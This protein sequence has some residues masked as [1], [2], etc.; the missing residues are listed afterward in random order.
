MIQ[1][2][3]LSLILII[4]AVVWGGLLLL[5]GVAVSPSW[6]RPLSGVTAVL[7]GLIGCFDLFLWR[8][9]ILQ[10]W[11]VKRPIL[12]G[13]W[14][15]KLVSNWVNPE[16]GEKVPPIPAYVVIR[17]TYSM[18]SIRLFTKESR[19]VV[20]GAE[21]IRA[22]DGTYSLVGVYRNDPKLEYRY[23]SEIHHG[24]ILLHVIGSPVIRLEGQ[25]WTDR[26]T[27]GSMD[28]TRR[29]KKLADDFVTAKEHMGDNIGVG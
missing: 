17:Q 2:L 6:A 8:I 22:A 9:T 13:T 15:A 3:H 24:G 20:L 26:N 1:R 10:G 7:L 23:R 16:T 19:S 29:H 4:G 14:A 18:L 27:A 28:L 5:Q 11:L 25:Y 21:I 12:R